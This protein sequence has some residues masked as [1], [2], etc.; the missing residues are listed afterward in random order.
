MEKMRKNRKGYVLGVLLFL[1]IFGQS[2]VSAEKLLIPVGQTVGVTLFLDGVT[3]VDTAEVEDSQGKRHTP[4]KDAGIVPGDI[5]T[6]INGTA[7][8]SATQLEELVNAQ[9]ASPLSIKIQNNEGEKTV[10]IQPERSADDGC[11]R[12]GVWIKDAASGIGTVTY[13]DPETREFGALGHGISENPNQE[14]VPIQGGNILNAAIVSIQKGEKGC[15]GELVGVFSEDREKLGSISA[16]TVVGLKGTL[17]PKA[18]LIIME[19]PLP[20]ADRHTVHRG[21]AEILS[22]V[23]GNKIQRFSAE[24]QR[25]NKDESSTKGMVIKITDPKLLE[26]TGGIVQGM[27]GSPIIQDGKLVGAV[28]HVFVNDPTRGYGIFI[29]NML[30]EA[31]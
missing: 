20:T 27:S 18:E 17:D 4:A 11:Y 1:L 24:I 6:E 9:G 19:P 22:H 29:E 28:T 10:R 31:E 26:K 16:N 2:A 12:L 8:R 14:T 7:I 23:E 21:E 30:A 25:I 3:I 13:F 15:P 5:V